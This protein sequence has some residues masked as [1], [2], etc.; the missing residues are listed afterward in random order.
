[1]AARRSNVRIV[2]RSEKEANPRIITAE[3]AAGATSVGGLP[4]PVLA[5]VAF[6]GRSNVGKSTL[7]NALLQRR[8]LV[9]TSRTPGCTRQINLFHAALASGLELNLADLPGYGYAKVSKKEADAW[10][11]MLEGYLSERITL[12]AVAVLVDVRRGVREEEEQLL[13]FLNEPA[14]VDRPKEVDVIIVAT[15]IDKL[16]FSER[17]PAISAIEKASKRKVYGMS[18]ETGEGRA[19][20][21]DRLSKAVV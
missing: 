14:E 5:E 13:E 6:A 15:K 1:M 9:R 11:P 19:A 17:K 21:W 20:L 3:F 18:G 4:A 8:N 7:L 12:R 16:S 2:S 10:R